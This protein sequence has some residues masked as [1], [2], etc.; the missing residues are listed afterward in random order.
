M[1]FEDIGQII[2][3]QTNKGLKT[4]LKV[5]FLGHDEGSIVQKAIDANPRYDDIKFGWGVS[6]G[7]DSVAFY[8]FEEMTPAEFL[9]RVMHLMMEVIMELSK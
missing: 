7:G 2:Q 3:Y 6:P 4:E 1:D 8:T 9:T 5:G